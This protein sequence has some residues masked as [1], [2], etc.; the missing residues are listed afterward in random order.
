VL[1]RRVDAANF[2]E[3]ILD[4]APSLSTLTER[5]RLVPAL[6]HAV[7]REV[8]VHDFRLMYEVSRD[9][10]VQARLR[11][12]DDP[13]GHLRETLRNP[14]VVSALQVS[15]VVG[16]DSLPLKAAGFRW[17]PWPVAKVWLRI[18]AAFTARNPFRLAATQAAHRHS[19]PLAATQAVRRHSRPLAASRAARCPSQA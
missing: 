8:F 5:G 17:I 9:L 18:Q 1:A 10:E 19:R 2:L 7:T 3:E 4:A 14:F 6:A 13:S 11:S 16:R 12:P 15:Q